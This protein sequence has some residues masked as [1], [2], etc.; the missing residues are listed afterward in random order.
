[1]QE[2]V[3]LMRDQIIYHFSL[4]SVWETHLA[5]KKTRKCILSWMAYT[6]L[7]KF[8]WKRRDQFLEK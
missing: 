8:L 1:M 4:H 2:I 7:V 5:I 3:I 6:H